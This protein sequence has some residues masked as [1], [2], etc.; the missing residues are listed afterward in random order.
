MTIK[1]KSKGYAHTI[2]EVTAEPN[3][4]LTKEILEERFDEPFGCQVMCCN[5]K[6][7]IVKSYDD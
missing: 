5:G 6:S 4:V 2:Y 7:A 1:V 3:E